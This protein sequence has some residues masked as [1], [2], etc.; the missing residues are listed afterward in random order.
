MSNRSELRIPALEIRQGQARKLYS[1]AIDGK[2][3]PSFVA[4]S[5]LRRGFLAQTN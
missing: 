3:L 2:L 1:F 5:R 4:V